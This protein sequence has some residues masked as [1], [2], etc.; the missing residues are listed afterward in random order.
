MQIFSP[1]L[2]DVKKKSF[3]F[4]RHNQSGGVIVAEAINAM[5]T[6]FLH[7]ICVK[8]LLPNMDST[9]AFSCSARHRIFINI[10]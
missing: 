8:L 4:S 5:I 9:R 2:S 7:A 1:R 3:F 6:L 10:F